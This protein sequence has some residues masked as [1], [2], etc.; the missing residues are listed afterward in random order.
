MP[1]SVHPRISVA[2]CT[3]NGASHLQ[4]QLHSIASQS[5][6][7]AELVVCDDGSTD[8]TL[9]LL[10]EFARTAP[11]PVHIQQ[12]PVNL[13]YTRNFEKAIA[14]CTGEFIA[15]S[16]QDD[17]WYPEK[18][19]TQASLL[20]AEPAAGGVFSDG[21][22]MEPNGQIGKRSLWQSIHFGSRQQSAFR[23]GAEAG[24][25][26][27]RNVVTGMTLMI[28]ARERDTL[29]PIPRSWVHDAWL[30]WMLCLNSKLIPCP[31]RLVAYRIHVS[32]Q[33]GVPMSPRQKLLWVLK[34]GLSSYFAR[35]REKS[36][37]EYRQTGERLI[38]LIAYV[39]ARNSGPASA[40]VLEQ[41]E[42]KLRHTKLAAYAMSQPRLLRLRPILGSASGYFQ[43]SALPLRA[44]IRDL[45]L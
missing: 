45:V 1:P 27:R 24:V 33:M 20:I 4:Q 38:E 6:L 30:A 40:S 26:L 11:F 2:L 36:T 15:L 39:K 8:S 13:G 14:L 41:I 25:L 10:T 3:Y 32:Q 23:A 5:L 34:N 42:H 31:D 44:L 16:D 22:L 9:D 28:R 18:L 19:A 29:L 35:A 37:N 17:L 12:N 43:Y 7:P 21:D